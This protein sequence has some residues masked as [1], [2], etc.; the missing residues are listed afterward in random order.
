[1]FSN[2]LAS[3]PE[4]KL[5]KRCKM[6][7]WTACVALWAK[8]NIVVEKSALLLR[9]PEDHQFLNQQYIL[10]FLLAF[11]C[12]APKCMNMNRGE[13]RKNHLAS[14]DCSG[15]YS[16]IRTYLV[17]AVRTIPSQSKYTI[18]QILLNTFLLSMTGRP[19]CSN[20]PPEEHF[21]T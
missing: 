20:F 1:M 9:S 17:A 16:Y 18:S 11:A 12:Q 19:N 8:Q 2:G 7:G 21:I 3:D 14:T 6:Q 13:Y 4:Q 5:I 10:D 15:T